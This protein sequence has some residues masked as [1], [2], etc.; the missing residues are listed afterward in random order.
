M[1]L[2]RFRHCQQPPPHEFGTREH[3]TF[4][5][6]AVGKLHLA[7]PCHGRILP[8]LHANGT[9]NGHARYCHG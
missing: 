8:H 9:A 1:V 5:Y 6:Y 3:V 2:E 4:W 7:A